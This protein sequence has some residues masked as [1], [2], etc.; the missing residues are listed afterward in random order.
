MFCTFPVFVLSRKGNLKK[1]KKK[2]EISKQNCSKTKGQII[3]MYYMLCDSN[4]IR[5]F[6]NYKVIH[7]YLTI[8]LL[9][10]MHFKKHINTMIMICCVFKAKYVHCKV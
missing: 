2:K 5:T 3:K 10:T 1:K 8:P 6:K 9:K 4:Y 7:S